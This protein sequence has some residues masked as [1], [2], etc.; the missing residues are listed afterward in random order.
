MRC[1]VRRVSRASVCVDQQV[2]G[3]IGNGLLVYLGI[4][5]GDQADDMCWVLKKLLGI[6]VFDDPEGKMNESLTCDEGI[7]LISQFTLFGNLKKGFRPSF[8]RAAEP[9]DA[10]RLFEEFL[11]RLQSEFTGTVAVGAF[12]EHMDIEAVDDG[13]VSLWLDSRQRGY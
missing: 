2:I 10:R 12:G 4:E 5:R 9:L 1:L 11:N 13:P 7:M 8:N 6:R 3:E